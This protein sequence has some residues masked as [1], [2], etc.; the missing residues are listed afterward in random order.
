MTG[1]WIKTEK[2]ITF[3]THLS[4]HQFLGKW[5]VDAG[6]ADNIITI[7]QYETESEAKSLLNYIF[8][9]IEEKVFSL[10][11]ETPGSNKE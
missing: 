4:V 10:E 9:H 3:A 7:A 2:N 5:I 8:G 6:I 1:I 11:I